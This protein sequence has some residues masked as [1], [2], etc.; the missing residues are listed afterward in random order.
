MTER[1]FE[2]PLIEKEHAMLEKI[3]AMGIALVSLTIGVQLS[4]ISNAY[5]EDGLEKNVVS[6]V[7]VLEGYI[8]SD[9][10][11]PEPSSQK[12]NLP[13]LFNDAGKVYAI[14]KTT[15][16]AGETYLKH[17][18]FL[19]DRIILDA[20]VPLKEDQIKSVSGLI[21]KPNW[22]GKWRVDITAQDGTLLY[23]I[24]FVIQKKP[25]TQQISGGAPFSMSNG[26]T[27]FSHI[28]MT[29]PPTTP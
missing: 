2:L 26:G 16:P 18:W 27:P 10:Y 12:E 21:L 5:G 19:R 22:T 1:K 29:N 9:S 17:L 3:L 24:P 6:E 25:E 8:S 14:A 11:R 13:V 7:K 15:R 23:S 20:K 4:I 28:S